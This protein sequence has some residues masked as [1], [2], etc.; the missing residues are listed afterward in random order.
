MPQDSMALVNA[1]VGAA[2]SAARPEKRGSS[3]AWA[4]SSP[5]GCSMGLLRC[6]RRPH[7]PTPLSLK[8]EGGS[9]KSSL[10][11]SP[12]PS[13]FRERG[14]GGVR[15]AGKA[16]RQKPVEHPLRRTHLRLEALVH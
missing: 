5:R 3:T 14:A 1:R 12:P 6:P 16:E 8:G 2:R 4:S 15:S 7:P 13:P 9:E 11:R 10:S